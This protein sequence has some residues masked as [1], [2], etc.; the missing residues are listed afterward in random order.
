MPSKKTNKKS[1]PRKASKN[2]PTKRKQAISASPRP[3][4]LPGRSTG[5]T[6]SK[7]RATGG[8]KPKPTKPTR[9]GNVRKVNSSNRTSPKSSTSRGGQKSS[10]FSRDAKALAKETRKT[11]RIIASNVKATKKAVKQLRDAFGRFAK[12]I[13]KAS[14]ATSRRQNNA[15]KQSTAST[16]AKKAASKN[17][18]RGSAAKPGT[19]KT[20][21]QV[22][23]T[24]RRNRKQGGSKGTQGA[25]GHSKGSSGGGNRPGRK[26]ATKPPRGLT[27]GQPSYTLQELASSKAKNLAKLLAR[28][29]EN[30]ASIDLLKEPE[31]LWAFQVYDKHSL[32]VYASIAGMMEFLQTSGASTQGLVKA[33]MENPNLVMK[34][35][36]LTKGKSGG[37]MADAVSE[38]RVEVAERQR[39][40][41]EKNRAIIGKLQKRFGRLH[42]DGRRKTKTDLLDEAGAEIEKLEAEARMKREGVKFRRKKKA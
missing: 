25:G 4:P 32:T 27:P 17:Q 40:L 29:E 15:A 10:A 21:S 42:P 31:Q 34:I 23:A 39:L 30:A 26:P 11:S 12:A 35:S 18:A 36:I 19:A 16:K 5:A 41:R 8:G 3:K 1:A 9:P 28:I 2:A 37:K 24:V 33:E 13:K 6:R 7:A 22:P 38:Y 14:K 20:P